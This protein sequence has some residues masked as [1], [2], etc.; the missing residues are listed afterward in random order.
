[1]LAVLV[2]VGDVEDVAVLDAGRGR[3]PAVLAVRR[4]RHFERAIEACERR[5]LFVVEALAG[6]HDDGIFV[7]RAL[8]RVP[9]RSVDARGEIGAGQFGGE[10]RMQWLGRNAHD[11]LLQAA[12]LL[13]HNS[14]VAIRAPSDSERSFAHMMLG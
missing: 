4:R 6:Q 1:M 9:R 8:D 14:A 11:G 13:P 7:H 10:Q 5:L 2:E 12:L 3:R